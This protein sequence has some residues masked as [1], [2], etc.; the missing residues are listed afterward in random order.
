MPAMSYDLDQKVFQ[1]LKP[2]IAQLD[3]WKGAASGIAD[4]V[5]TW[6]VERFWAMSRSSVLKGGG[7]PDASSGNADQK[8][9]FAWGVARVVLCQIAGADLRIQP[10]MTTDQFQTQFRD[11]GFNQQVLMTDLL[12]EI[13]DAIQFWTMRIT[14]AQASKTPV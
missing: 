1:A 6:G 11:L 4:Y 12:I 9:Y 5:A 3:D 7:L 13:A 14:D 8:R 2:G 10:E